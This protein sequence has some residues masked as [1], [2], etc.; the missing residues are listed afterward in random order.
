MKTKTQSVTELKDQLIMA[1]GDLSANCNKRTNIQTF[2]E[3]ALIA[4]AGMMEIVTTNSRTN[5]YINAIRFKT[6][7]LN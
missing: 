3:I 4:I 5:D 2:A 6:A 1:V 7:E